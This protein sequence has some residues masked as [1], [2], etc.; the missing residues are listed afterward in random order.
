M[1]RGMHFSRRNKGITNYR[2]RLALLKSGIPRAVVR[3]SNAKVTV[4][5]IEFS[6]KGDKVLAS[7][8]SSDVAGMGWKGSKTNVPASYL[9]GMLAAKRALKAGINNAVLDI[10]RTT[11]T[12]GGRAF[13]ALKGL[14][15]G[16]LDIP[17]SDKL[18]PGDER[19]NGSHISD[20]TTTEFE[21]VSKKIGGSK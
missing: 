17:H 5:I 13:A 21:K 15:D 19:I 3:F 2:K 20:K 10:G 11:P 14:V 9:S 6:I 8:T 1:P 16:G 7:A 12:P 18:F 4:Q